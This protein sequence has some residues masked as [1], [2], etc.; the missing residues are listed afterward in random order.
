LGVIEIELISEALLVRLFDTLEV[1]LGDQEYGEAV[2]VM[3]VDGEK[4]EEVLSDGERVEVALSD[5]EEEEDNK[6]QSSNPR[7]TPTAPK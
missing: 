3:V 4:V 7:R 1:M 5:G 6:G 2:E